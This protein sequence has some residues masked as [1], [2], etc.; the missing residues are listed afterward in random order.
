MSWQDNVENTIF[1]IRTGDGKLYTPDLPVNYETI[2][3]FNAAT[4]EFIDQ[5]G[6]LITR[7]LVRARK[8]ELIFY[9]QGAQNIETADAFDTSANDPRAWV[10]RHPQYG[11]ITGQPISIRRNDAKLNAT[12]IT[13]DFWETL[14]TQFPAPGIVDPANEGKVLVTQFHTISPINYAS[15]VNLKPA[16]VSM[17]TTLATDITALIKKSVDAVNYTSF[18]TDVNTM[19]STINN[20]IL[21]PVAAITA[22]HNVIL[23]PSKFVLSVGLRI[24]M[25]GAVY[26]SISRLLTDAGTKNN[27]AFFETAAGITVCSLAQAIA[28]PLPGDYVTRDQVISAANNLQDM[29]ADYLSMMD[30][31]YVEIG[32]TNNSFSTSQ[33]TQTA[34]QDVVF[35]ALYNLNT[36]AFNAKVERIVLLTSDAQLVVLTHKYMGLDALDA[37][38]ETFRIINNLKNNNVFLVPK[39]TQIKYYV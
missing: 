15:K 11:D 31:A 1:T 10:V 21:A 28:T 24:Q 32:D 36:V 16:D 25:I 38:I 2:K 39:G 13:I 35:Q 18:I 29:Y 27:K 26:Q 5:P 12:E 8:F 7:K 4:F 9:F 22:I 19:M 34:L 33:E 17:I 14:V 23:Q 6:A 37:N 20:L 3:E 30:L